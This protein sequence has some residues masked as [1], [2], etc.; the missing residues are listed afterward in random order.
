LSF[1]HF[2]VYQRAS[3]I[4]RNH[5]SLI[6]FLPALGVLF[7]QIPTIGKLRLLGLLVARQH[8][9]NQNLVR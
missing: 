3:L 7:L 5:F 1:L 6:V 4:P 9:K 8:R 2:V